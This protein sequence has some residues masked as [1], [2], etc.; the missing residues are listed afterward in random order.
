MENGQWSREVNLTKC[1]TDEEKPF[2]IFAEILETG[3]GRRAEAKLEIDP[4]EP[5]FDLIPLR[6][7]FTLE[8]Q[9]V[10]VYVSKNY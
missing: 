2:L 3:A 6:P 7:G 9:Y 1:I 5:G 8:S 10:P 4:G